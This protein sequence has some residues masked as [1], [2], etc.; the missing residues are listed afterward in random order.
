MRE[1]IKM[2]QQRLVISRLTM[3]LGRKLTAALLGAEETFDNVQDF[4]LVKAVFISQLE[5]RPLTAAKLAAYVGM[6]RPTV[7]RRMQA[8]VDRGTV[9]RDDSGKFT[10]PDDSMNRP[11]AV[12]CLNSAIEA[13]KEAAAEL[14]KMD[15]AT[16]APS[17]DFQD[18]SK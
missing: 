15:A 2:A 4:V 16:V 3:K 18:Q 1:E 7:V 12:A 11:E 10:V 13:V 5:G 17:D 14:S 9:L 8:L 6:P